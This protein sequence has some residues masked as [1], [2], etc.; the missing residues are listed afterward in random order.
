MTLVQSLLQVRKCRVL[1]YHG[2]RLNITASGEC[3][4][5]RR[6]KIGELS[7]KLALLLFSPEGCKQCSTLS[8]ALFPQFFN[9]LFAIPGEL[10]FIL[11]ETTNHR[12]PRRRSGT[13]FLH[14]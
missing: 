9:E 6:R 13:I 4:E 2:D 5:R 7:G 12:W 3:D 8:P 10:I 11:L 1:P 14:I